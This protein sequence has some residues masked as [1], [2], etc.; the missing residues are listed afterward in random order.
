MSIL[1]I[2][3]Q[4][5]YIKFKVKMKKKIQYMDLFMYTNDDN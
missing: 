5:V 1:Y 2:G 3:T 4:Y